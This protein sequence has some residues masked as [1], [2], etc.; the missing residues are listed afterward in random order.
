VLDALQRAQGFLDENGTVLTG[1]DLTTARNRLDDVVASFTT[2][3]LNQDVGA[4]GAKGETEKQRQLRITI[5]RDQ[6][7]PIAII[8]RQNLKSTPEFKALQMPRPSSHGPAFVAS[9]TGMADAAMLHKDL[10]VG[11]GLQP[12]FL[13]DLKAGIAKYETSLS[14]RETH[15]NQRVGATKG[16]AVEERN[17]RTILKILDPQVMQAAGNDESLL[18][19]WQS[20]RLIRRRSGRASGVAAASGT[21]SEG[22]TAAA[23]TPTA[24]KEPASIV[25]MPLPVSGSA[26]AAAA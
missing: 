2:H 10:L 7:R 17:G 9:G 4:R 20:A 22:T 12:T 13:E 14:D 24:V 25:S 11:H 8:A 3:A 21:T 19:A 18:R 16:L 6:M 26:P 1:L 15:R 23:Q 5:R